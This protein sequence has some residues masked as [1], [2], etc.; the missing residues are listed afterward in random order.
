LRRPAGG[1]YLAPVVILMGRNTQT[2]T[3]RGG[4]ISHKARGDGARV[5]IFLA[6]LAAAYT[7]AVEPEG[8]DAAITVKL[9][10]GGD[11]QLSA[12]NGNFRGAIK[13]PVDSAFRSLSLAQASTSPNILRNLKKIV[14]NTVIG[15]DIE[16]WG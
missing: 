10:T 1:W 2:H 5:D 14:K 11:V 9:R 4:R 7:S 16:G 6:T 12:A 13:D 8:A 15:V 3:Q